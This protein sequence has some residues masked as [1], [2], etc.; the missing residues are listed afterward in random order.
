MIIKSFE[1]NK[2]NKEKANIILLYGENEGFKNQ[3]I[4]EHF[5]NKFKNKKVEKYDEIEIL[6]NYENFL[7]NLLNKSFF[8]DEKIIIISRTS[9][10]ILSLVEEIFS[11]NDDK[12][13]LI[14]NSGILEKKSK[15]RNYFEKEKN[16]IC[17]PFYSDNINTLS[18]LANE[19]F[20]K[21]NVSISREIIN[22]ISERCN[23]DRKNLE[24]ELNKI[25]IYLNGES[26]ITL[27]EIEK[28]TNLAE[29]YSISELA[30]NCLS[31]NVKK[32]VKILN[33][34]NFTSDDCMQITRTLLI[35]LKRILEL[36]KVCENE[37]NIDD[38]ISGFK[39]P[40]FWKDKTIVK[41]QI[42]AWKKNE[43]E[44]LVN[45]IS[46]IELLIK[47]NSVNS[48]SII[49]DFILNTSSKN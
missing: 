35:K 32:T 24:N 19:F 47:K 44:K 46:D 39:P 33:E 27:E 37:N 13:L 8:D 5:I 28:L 18:S 43:A 40:I 34:N 20:R 10:K 23:G 14:L 15:L 25:S 11:K 21:K 45:K 48:L 41:S 3:V 30:D 26:K 6:N 4:V 9:D 49:S 38:A 2:L 31:K 12:I 36:K 17:I 1:L 7:S 29:N 16:L 42:L 22:L